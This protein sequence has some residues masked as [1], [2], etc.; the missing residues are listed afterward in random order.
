MRRFFGIELL[1]AAWL[2]A[3]V[4]ALG[5]GAPTFRAYP[6]GPRY[7][8]PCAPLRLRPHTAAWQFR[9]RIREAAQGQPNFAGHCVLATWGCGA[10][11]LS[12]AI[13]DV[14]TGAVYFDGVTTC[15]W[16]GEGAVPARADFEPI[17]FRLSSRLVVFTGLLNEK[18][19]NGPHYFTFERGHLLARP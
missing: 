19:R 15:C 6:A 7:R 11:C 4:E 18:G 17:D 16:F 9:T 5:Q 3:P 2:L 12:Y 13:I 1:L 10:E 14:R 8:G